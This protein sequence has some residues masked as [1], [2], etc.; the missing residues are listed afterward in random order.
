MKY[1]I[2]KPVHDEPAPRRTPRKRTSP[3]QADRDAERARTIAASEEHARLMAAAE[4][5]R[6]IVR[7][8]REMSRAAALDPLAYVTSARRYGDAREYSDDMEMRYG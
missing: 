2:L 4:A 7:S 3:T 1:R 6:A 5:V 8:E